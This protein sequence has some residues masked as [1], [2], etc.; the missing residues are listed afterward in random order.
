MSMA[1]NDNNNKKLSTAP[2]KTDMTKTFLHQVD[3]Q[4]TKDQIF[5]REIGI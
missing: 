4:N 1:E 5:K 2:K 3:N